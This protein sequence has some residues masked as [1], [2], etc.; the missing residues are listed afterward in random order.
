MH[1]RAVRCSSEVLDITGMKPV[2]GRFL[3]KA[4]EEPGNQRVVVLA[5][6][7][8]RK[9]FQA[10]KDVLGKIISLNRGA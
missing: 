1:L 3:T 7:V 4:D 9:N 5:E 6:H 2:V 8:W 10:R